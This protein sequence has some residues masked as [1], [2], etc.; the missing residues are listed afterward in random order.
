[1]VVWYSSR[2]NWGVDSQMYGDAVIRFDGV[3]KQ[4]NDLK[5]FEELDLSFPHSKIIL[6]GPN[7]TGKSTFMKICYGMSSIQAGRV[8]VTDHDP[9][10]ERTMVKRETS[11]LPAETVF[12]RSL[13]VESILEYISTFCDSNRIDGLVNSLNAAYLKGKIVRNLSSG[14]RQVTNLIW[15][16]SQKRQL[17]LLDEPTSSLDKNRR[18]QFVDILKGVNQAAIITSHEYNELITS[19]E[20]ICQIHQDP[21]TG[22]SRFSA[23]MNTNETVIKVMFFD[24]YKVIEFLKSINSDFVLDG[25]FITV[26]TKVAEMLSKFGNDIAFLKRD[27]DNE[28]V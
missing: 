20:S 9:F 21:V 19:V 2:N 12:P 7:G 4:F 22:L 3:E 13:S 28:S 16:L 23:V 8:S 10:S 18:K 6:I 5:I 11:Y 25:G 14:E 15:A 1:M 17:Y 26:Y 27:V 24:N